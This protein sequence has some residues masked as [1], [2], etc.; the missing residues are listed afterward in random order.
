MF[1]FCAYLSPFL[2]LPLDERIMYKSIQYR[3]ERVGVVTQD[4]E[5]DFAGV[6]VHT[7]DT[8]DAQRVDEIVREAE[9]DTL[10][11]F[12]QLSTLEETV[13]VYMHDCTSVLIEQNVLGVPIAKT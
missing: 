11:D 1:K 13:K 4:F 10:R 3:H 8:D 9:R 12:Q 7:L 2:V 6:T 5:G